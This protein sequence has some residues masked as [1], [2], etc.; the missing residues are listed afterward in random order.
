MYGMHAKRLSPRVRPVRKCVYAR[1][2][3]HLGERTTW[4][5]TCYTAVEPCLPY[6][7]YL[8]RKAGGS[9]LP[10]AQASNAH[11]VCTAG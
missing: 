11:D 7:P 1:Q 8:R 6:F 2:V 5:G 10:Q 9:Q 4:T 3:T